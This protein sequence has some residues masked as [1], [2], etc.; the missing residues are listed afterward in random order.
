MPVLLTA[1]IDA[2]IPMASVRIFLMK[3]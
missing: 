1:T 2:G 3:R